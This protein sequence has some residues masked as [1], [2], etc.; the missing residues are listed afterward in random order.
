MK[1][2]YPTESSMSNHYTIFVIK[3]CQK[4]FEWLKTEL[5]SDKVLALY[6]PEEQLVLACD[7]SQHGLSAI[8][9]HRYKDG[10]ER[11]IAF[12]SKIIPK[13]ELHRAIIDKEAGAII[14]GF[15]KFY[16]YI[17][18][19]NIILKTDHKPLKFIFGNK[20]MSTMLHSRLQR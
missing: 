7:A 17:Y 10:T 18:G 1:N 8:L 5:A 13:S 15:K 19:N 2:F 9:S 16:Q 14:F 6:D 11:P 4:K 3:E 12:A 20:N